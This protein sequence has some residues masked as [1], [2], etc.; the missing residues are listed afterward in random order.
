L[1]TKKSILAVDDEWQIINVL[2]DYFEMFVPE[3]SV[4]TFLTLKDGLKHALEHK[5]ELD[6]V[7]LDGNL[8]PGFGW[9]I[10]EALGADYKG[11]IFCL[12]GQSFEESVPEEKRNLYSGFFCK[13]VD[14]EALIRE[15]KEKFS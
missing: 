3:W 6:A 12:A 4:T 2:K 10:A 1:D 7:L 13:P 14:Y 11:V 8:F 9:E 15:L 5:E